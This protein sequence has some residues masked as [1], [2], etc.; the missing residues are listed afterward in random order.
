MAITKA[1]ELGYPTDI[2]QLDAGLSLIIDDDLLQEL[3]TNDE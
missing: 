2:L 1:V 3:L